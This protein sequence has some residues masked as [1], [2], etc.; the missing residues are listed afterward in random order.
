MKMTLLLF[1]PIFNFWTV[2]AQD[3]FSDKIL[4]QWEAKGKSFG[5]PSETTMIWERALSGKFVR[6]IYRIVMHPDQGTDQIFEGEAMY[7]NSGVNSFTATWFDSQGAIHPIT[8]THDESTL[9]SLWGTP[10]TTSQGKT[11]YTLKEGT[12]EVEDFIMTKDGEWK[13]FN[14]GVFNKN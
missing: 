9:I 7:K 11:I 3:N 2:C 14:K 13:Q 12:L 5:L 8:A 1:F 4:G 10:N 6:L